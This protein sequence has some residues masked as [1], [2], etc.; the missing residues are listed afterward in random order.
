MIWITQEDRLCSNSNDGRCFDFGI[1][2]SSRDDSTHFV[3]R[4]NRSSQS[5]SSCRNA[6]GVVLKKS[7]KVVTCDVAL[8]APPIRSRVDKLLCTS[9][10]PDR[11]M[12]FRFDG[13][14]KNFESQYYS[15]INPMIDMPVCF[16][17]IES[18][19]GKYRSRSSNA[20]D[21]SAKSACMEE[22]GTQG[23]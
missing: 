21:L 22:D 1:V 14:L 6:N 20:I 3:L 16:A 19:T 15:G 7:M 13:S 17:V 2:C 5:H 4:Q 18:V 11:L 9:A 23:D 10:V 8:R 12:S